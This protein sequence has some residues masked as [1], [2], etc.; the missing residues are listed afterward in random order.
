MDTPPQVRNY[1]IISIA[2]FIGFSGLVL[3][4]LVNILKK[5]AILKRM[6]E[7]LLEYSGQLEEANSVIEEHNAL[8][9]ELLEKRTKKLIQTERQAA[10][11]QLIQGIVHNLN[12]PLCSV[13]GSL[14]LIEEK[15]K[16]FSQVDREGEIYSTSK[17]TFETMKRYA[18]MT[19][20]SAEKLSTMITSM[21]VKS[22]SDKSDEL[23][24]KDL[25][26]IIKLEMDFL[27]ADHRFKHDVVKSF[28]FYEGE[29]RI[30]VIPPEIA[31]VFHNLIQNSL[32]AL[33][34]QEDAEIIIRTS[35]RG[36]FAAFTVS[37]NGTGIPEEIIPK[38]FDPFFTS[39]PMSDDES[40]AEPS[41]TG[42]GLYTCNETIKTYDGK[43][44][45]ESKLGR[46]TSFTVEIPLYKEA[47]VEKE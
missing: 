28:D 9:E 1:I 20:G 15:F 47:K 2:V 11:G 34:Q 40:A 29:L 33:H 21:M 30:E 19:R 17:R 45:V 4:L 8:L 18:A 37:D 12:N 10:F 6:H 42:L 27:E 25:H 31:Q 36:D 24:I 5:R 7:S 32:D 26:K 44:E 35:M 41:G 38:L 13:Y 16:D 22:R 23:E 3:Y 43:I 14:Q 39:K 46:G